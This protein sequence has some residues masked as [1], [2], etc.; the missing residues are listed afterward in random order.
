MIAGR[1]RGKKEAPQQ[2]L[3][4]PWQLEKTPAEDLN[5]DGSIPVNHKGNVYLYKPWMVPNG[6]FHFT[7][8]G[9]GEEIAK[10]AQVENV[11]AIVAWVFKKAKYFP[12]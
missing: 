8:F 1:A 3:F 9:L 6:C 4:G 11:Q 7:E 5:D 10:L 2:K 12:M